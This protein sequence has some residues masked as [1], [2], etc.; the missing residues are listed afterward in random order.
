MKHIPLFIAAVVILLVGLV[1]TALLFLWQCV[2]HLPEW[3][4]FKWSRNPKIQTLIESYHT[5]TY[6]PKHHYWTGLLLIFRAVLYLITAANISNDLTIALT[7]IT[8]TMGCVILLKG[9]IGSQLYV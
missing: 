8:F 3:K 2:L 9:F 6:T 4:I 1:Y 5:H 7:V